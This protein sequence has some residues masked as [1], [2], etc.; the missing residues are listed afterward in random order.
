LKG[1]FEAYLPIEDWHNVKNDAIEVT[2]K[3]LNG[4]LLLNYMGR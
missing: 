2:R 4:I 1:N 3:T